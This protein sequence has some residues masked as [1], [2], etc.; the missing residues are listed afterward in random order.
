MSI[1]TEFYEVGLSK[2]FPAFFDDQNH[3]T[4]LNA[5]PYVTDLNEL[6]NSLG[7]NQHRRRLAKELLS[8][9]EIAKSGNFIFIHAIFG[10]TFID[11]AVSRPNDI[12]CAFFYKCRTNASQ[13]D[14]TKLQISQ[15]QAKNSNIDI[16]YFPIDADPILAIKAAIFFGILYSCDKIDPVIRKGCVLVKYL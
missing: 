14:F 16:R 15:D 7:T 5:A 1:F 11:K 12:D 13:C 8:A 3:S 4:P 2:G 10:G 9:L 6:L